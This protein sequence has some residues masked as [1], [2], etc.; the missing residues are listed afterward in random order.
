MC[1]PA[2][3]PSTAYTPAVTVNL[4]S[5]P[6]QAP[7]AVEAELIPGVPP[8]NQK[9][10]V[11]WFQKNC[12]ACQN[13]KPVFE[14]LGRF[15]LTANPPF[16]VHEVEATPELLARFPHVTVVPLYDVV[17]PARPGVPAGGPYGARMVLTS[18][19]N[20]MKALSDAFPAFVLPPPAVPPLPTVPPAV[21]PTMPPAS[22]AAAAVAATLPPPIP[23]PS[24]IPDPTTAFP[25]P[26]PNK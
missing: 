16:T 13:S 14:A 21:P 26:V 24:V 23:L 20:D 5:S 25:S 12:V 15:G 2:G 6:A 8:F 9:R 19:R 17:E 4:A 7:R 10:V 22:T 3:I 18:I 1:P 11:I